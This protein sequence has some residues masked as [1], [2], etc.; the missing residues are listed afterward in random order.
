[1]K[2]DKNKTDTP[3]K[4]YY[5]V[6]SIVSCVYKCKKRKKNENEMTT[7]TYE[8]SLYHLKYHEYEYNDN[9]Y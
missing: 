7:N 4:N 3:E 2:E 8:K 5:I 6:Q 9:T 1:M